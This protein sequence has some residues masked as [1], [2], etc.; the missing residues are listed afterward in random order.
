MISQQKL[1]YRV[2]NQVQ[3]YAFMGLDYEGEHEAQHQQLELLID[4]DS[5]EMQI[6]PW[7]AALG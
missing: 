4:P 5:P 2:L 7:K 3:H 1:I 6:S